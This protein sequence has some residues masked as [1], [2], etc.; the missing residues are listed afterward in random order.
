MSSISYIYKK[1]L[2]TLLILITIIFVSFFALEII[3]GDPVSAAFGQK[4]P[5]IT[6]R[7]KFEKDLGLDKNLNERFKIYCK[8]IIKLDFG[9][10]YTYKEEK[11]L[12]LVWTSLKTTLL[13]SII[14][15]ILGSVIGIYLGSLAALWNNTKKS[16]LLELI[17]FTLYCLPTFVIGFVLQFFLAF[18]FKIFKISGSP[19]LPIIVLSLSIVSGSIFK[20]T[21]TSMK[22]ILKQPYIMT[23]YAKGLSKKI[24]IF[25]H[26]L[27]N[28]LIPII[29]QIG[30]ILNSLISGA[31]ITETIFNLNGIGKLIMTAF[32]NRDYPIIRCCM[33][34]LTFFIVICNLLID[35]SF[36]KINPK[37][38]K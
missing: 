1:L 11:T 10:S 28:A 34:L 38:E 30:L 36:L 12:H 18:R 37:I 2:Y 19:V 33:I 14:S 35:I 9:Y 32:E 17:F 6:Q 25:K 7:K 13:L 24:V 22:E 15:C 21:Y 27:K 16:F 26:A 29:S 5:T 20:I 31:I 4:G 8:N 3:P 23:A